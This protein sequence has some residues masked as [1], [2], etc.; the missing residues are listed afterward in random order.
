[1]DNNDYEYRGLIASSWDL[2]RGDTSDWPDRAFYREIILDDGQ[3]ALDVGCGTGRLLLDYLADGIDVDGVDVSPE[4]LALCRNKA[5]DLG[6]HPNLYQQNMEALNLDCTYRTIFVP[7][8]SFQLLTELPTAWEALRRFYLHLESGGTLVMSIMDVSKDSSEVWQFIGER[9][10]PDDDLLVRRWARSDYD[11]TTQLEHTEDRYD[12]VKKD[13]EVIAS[14]LYR[15][16]PA[17]RAYTL[18]QITDMLLKTGYVNIRAVSGF[19]SQPASPDDEL[20]CVF[21]RRP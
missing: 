20:F 9:A 5:D 12:L 16:S 7:S 10:R 11:P 2:L 4:M 14:K 15:R 18:D 21:G 8:S 1:M 17:T 3:P 19:T 6:L 13:G